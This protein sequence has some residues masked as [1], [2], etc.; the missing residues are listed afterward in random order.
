VFHASWRRDGG[1]RSWSLNY[2]PE[3]FATHYAAQVRANWQVAYLFGTVHES[4][5]RMHAVWQ[6]G[7]G[8]PQTVP[9]W[10]D[11]AETFARNVGMRREA[12]YQLVELAPVVDGGRVHFHS[13]FRRQTE[14]TS[15]S[16]FDSSTSL[17]ETGERFQGHGYS[18]TILEVTV[19]SGAPHF[20]T[21]WARRPGCTWGWNHTARSLASAHAGHVRERRGMTWLRSYAIGETRL[22]AAVW[23]ASAAPTPRP[24]T[25]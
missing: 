18:P 15:W 25:P 6:D 10:F 16:I 7:R 12:G 20:H 1:D 11:R 19:A 14:P 24:A 5:Q 8:A 22:Y 2:A 21:V 3:D 4:A 9:N 23:C 17:Q 13:V